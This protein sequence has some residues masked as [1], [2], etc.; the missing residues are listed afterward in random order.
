MMAILA[1]MVVTSGI[2]LVLSTSS[3]E[4]IEILSQAYTLY[5]N[6]LYGFLG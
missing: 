3:A 1:T 4:R 5:L 6:D 2:I